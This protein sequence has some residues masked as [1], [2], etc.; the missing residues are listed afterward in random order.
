LPRSGAIP[1]ARQSVVA[2]WDISQSPYGLL[3]RVGEVERRVLK[4]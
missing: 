3:D 1:C 4:L 2:L